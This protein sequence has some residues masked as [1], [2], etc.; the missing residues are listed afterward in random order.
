MK[1]VLSVCLFLFLSFNTHASFWY[2][3]L[4]FIAMENFN[5]QKGSKNTIISFDFII[6]NPN[7]YN[8]SIK[9]SI[10]N[11]KIADTNCGD[12]LIKD[13]VNVKRKTKAIYKFSLLG[14]TSKFLKSGFS[15]IFK[16]LS[17]GKIDFV[18][19]GYLR[20][21]VFGITKKWRT[22]YTYAMTL[23]EFMSFF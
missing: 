4:E 19:A 7:W 3:D 13:K 9:P 8:I 23:D 1:P 12:V 17:Q 6:N 18:L 5:V 10:L 11:L 20:A 2:K 21:G 14:D 22:D 15:S 16:M